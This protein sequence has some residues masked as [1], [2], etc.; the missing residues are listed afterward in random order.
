[1]ILDQLTEESLS[2]TSRGVWPQALINQ[3]TDTIAGMEKVYVRYQQLLSECLKAITRDI[4]LT[5]AL[6]F[7]LCGGLLYFYGGPVQGPF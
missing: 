3:Q 1:M 7:F 6:L 4:I 5:T 2:L